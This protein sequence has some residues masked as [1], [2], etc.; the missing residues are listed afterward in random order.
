M[1]VM[2]FIVGLL[3]GVP[4]SIAVA[5]Q[6]LRKMRSRLEG[7]LADERQSRHEAAQQIDQLKAREHELELQVAKLESDLGAERQRSADRMQVL[8]EA[9]EQ[10]IALAKQSAGEA[11]AERG[12]ALVDTLKGELRVAKSEADADLARRQKAV[13]ETVQPVKDT[14]TRMATTLDQV[15]KDRRRSHAELSARLQGVTDATGAVVKSAATLDRALRQPHTRGR[16]G[17]LHLRRIVE[18]AGMSAHCDFSEQQQTTSADGTLRPDLVVHLPGGRDIVI[19]AKAPV[20]LYMEASNA[21]DE[22]ARS[23]R[24]KLFAR[25]VRAQVKKLASK[26]YSANMPQAADFVVLYL[27]GEQYFSAA[28]ETDPELI[29]DAI[30][31]GVHIASPTTLITMLR[32]TAY[33]WQQEKITEQ[34]QEVAKLGRDLYDRIVR[35]LTLA[36]TLAKRLNSTVSAHNELVGCLDGRVLP[37]ARRFPELGVTAS[38]REL[39][40]TRTITETARA[41]HGK[42]LPAPPTPHL[43]HYD[44]SQA[45][46]A[47]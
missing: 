45:A 5:R 31:V 11:V 47:A 17:E 13:E 22:N 43:E 37:A 16:W 7:E 35:L 26:D 21:E 4:A 40:A 15:D 29:E 6:G 25:G 20:E 44:N 28:S 23:A 14:L 18:A 12:K 10:M 46:E 2:W 19:D 9:S 42:E 27:P 32:T 36:D 24:M 1:Q 38:D 41:T 39:P 3:A 30:A 8:S 33:G 34:T